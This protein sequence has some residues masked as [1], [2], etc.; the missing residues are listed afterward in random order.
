MEVL[1]SIIE[2]PKNAGDEEIKRKTNRAAFNQQ[3][4]NRGVIMTD[5]ILKNLMQSVLI[6]FL[7]QSSIF[8]KSLFLC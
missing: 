3:R 1:L 5:E 6:V 8:I 4:S 2:K 7:S